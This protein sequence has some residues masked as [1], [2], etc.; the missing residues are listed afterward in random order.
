MR[1]A[2]LVFFFLLSGHGL[3]KIYEVNGQH[4]FVNFELDY[5]KVSRVKGAFEKFQGTFN[6]DKDS[7]KL[8]NLSF[9]ILVDSINTRDP[10]RDNHLKR[11]DFFYVT[12]FPVISFVGIKVIYKQGL[13]VKV[14]GDLSVRDV[15]RSHE[16]SIKWKGE[17]ADPVDKKKKS[18]FLE[19]STVIDRKDFNIRWN[20]AL[21][22]GGWVVGDI[23]NVEVIIE[24]NPTDKRPAFSRFYRKTQK[25]LPGKL[26]AP[27]TSLNPKKKA[28]NQQ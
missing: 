9:E 19:A 28:Q 2:F 24:A 22:Q 4:S 20:K 25:I 8:E 5:M 21:D 6:W 23:V 15:T 3:A 17:F 16:F 13:P 18:L 1:L 11:K 27:G 14:I 12:K 26:K 7:Q 10:K